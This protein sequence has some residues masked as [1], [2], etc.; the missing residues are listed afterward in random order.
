MNEEAG[1]GM[2]E[3]S[4]GRVDVVASTERWD[5]VKE[6]GQEESKFGVASGVGVGYGGVVMVFP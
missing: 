4:G 5:L 3:T 2:G 6:S 1:S